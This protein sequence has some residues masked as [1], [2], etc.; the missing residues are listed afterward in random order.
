MEQRH[1]GLAEV[2]S[3]R[4]LREARLGLELRPSSP[5]SVGLDL[6]SVRLPTP[7]DGRYSPTLRQLVPA[8]AAGVPRRASAG[9]WT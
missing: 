4:Y 6:R 8:E 1:Y 5:V 3:G 7:G 2:F 9:S